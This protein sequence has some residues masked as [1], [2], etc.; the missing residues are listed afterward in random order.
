MMKLLSHNSSTF[1]PTSETILNN[2]TE[3]ILVHTIVPPYIFTLCVTGLLGNGF[4]LL[5]FLLQRGPCTVP[6]IYLGNLAL[7]DLLLLACLPFWAMNILN[8]FNWPYGDFLCHIVSQSILVNTYTSIYLLTMVSVDRY[9]ALARTIRARWLRRK[10]YAWVVCLGLWLF[11]LL[12]GVLATVH[13]KVI[14]VDRLQTMAC[15]LEYPDHSTK[16]WKLANNLLMNIVGFVL[17]V[18]VI[19][20]C[21]GNIIKALWRR[22]EHVYIEYGNDRKANILI[23]SVTLLFLVCW[24]PFQ[25]FTLIDT[26]C[27]AELLDETWHQTLD[28]GTQ[29]STYL[30]FLNS[31]LNPVLYVFSGQYFRKKVSTIYRRTM[32]RRSSYSTAYQLS[33]VSTYLHRTDQIKPVV[34]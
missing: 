26:L 31:C 1:L 22:R 5:V 32:S 4:V 27:D 14:F 21:S 28:I 23:Y 34:I 29:F 10:C 30:A 2:T 15:V 18:I 20:S 8:D 25:L 13:R 3:W 17:P 16:S 12:L 19:I 7:A 9:L 24:S 6:E 11:G 33:V